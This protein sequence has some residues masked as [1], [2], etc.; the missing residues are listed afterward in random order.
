M[1]NIDGS[2]ELFNVRVHFLPI[3]EFLRD[4]HVLFLHLLQYSLVRLLHLLGFPLD[5]LDFSFSLQGSMV[6]CEITEGDPLYD[7]VLRQFLDCSVESSV[8]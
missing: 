4:G 8:F 3:V 7:H 5:A 6:D 1:S 2:A